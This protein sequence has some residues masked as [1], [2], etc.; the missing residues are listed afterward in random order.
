[1]LPFYHDKRRSL[2]LRGFSDGSNK[3]RPIQILFF[4]EGLT[5]HDV[6]VNCVVNIS[7]FDFFDGK[8]QTARLLKGSTLQRANYLQEI[9]T[10]SPWCLPKLPGGTNLDTCLLRLK[11]L[12]FWFDYMGSYMK[13]GKSEKKNPA[14][15]ACC[16][17]RSVYFYWSISYRQTGMGLGLSL[18]FKYITLW[19]KNTKINC[20]A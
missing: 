14:V 7:K 15:R 16:H 20:L 10:F 11:L 3:A 12:L 9:R 1:M 13:V 5:F 19:E 17:A 18:S 6:S 4:S 2:L 8:P